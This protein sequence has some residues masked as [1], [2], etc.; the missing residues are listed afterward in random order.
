MGVALIVN[1][2]EGGSFYYQT[3]MEKYLSIGSAS[4]SKVSRIGSKRSDPGFE[5]PP[6]KKQK[7]GVSGGESTSRKHFLNQLRAICDRWVVH[8]KVNDLIRETDGAGVVDGKEVLRLFIRDFLPRGKFQLVDCKCRHGNGRL[9][10]GKERCQTG[11]T[12]DMGKASAFV[13]SDLKKALYEWL[14]NRKRNPAD[15]VT[16]IEDDDS[17]GEDEE[18]DSELPSSSYDHEHYPSSLPRPGAKGYN[19]KSTKQRLTVLQYLLSHSQSR[20]DFSRAFAGLC[21]PELYLVHLCG[22]GLNSMSL[23]GSCVTGSH[24]K[25]A[26]AELNREH[27]HYHYVL[28]NAPSKESYLALLAAMKGSLEG[29]FDDVF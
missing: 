14:N 15:V 17:E 18:G 11:G 13:M 9:P 4:T 10:L 26:R 7:K 8:V 25:L 1:L 27:V 28:E 19:R 6:S 2:C 21:D 29:K 3:N 5:I 22:C 12:V 16:E 20:A 23:R 24:L